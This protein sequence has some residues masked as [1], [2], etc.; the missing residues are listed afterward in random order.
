MISNFIRPNTSPQRKSPSSAPSQ[1][2]QKRI[3]SGISSGYLFKAAAYLATYFLVEP[4]LLVLASATPSVCQANPD[5]SSCKPCSGFRVVAGNIEKAEILFLGEIHNKAEKTERCLSELTKNQ[6]KHTVLIEGIP[7]HMVVPCGG[8]IDSAAEAPGR[9]CIGWDTQKHM[10][11]G[12]AEN[13]RKVLHNLLFDIQN[14]LK[15]EGPFTAEKGKMTDVVLKN[16]LANIK[17]A[18]GY[19]VKNKNVPS[20]LL[21]YL[22]VDTSSHLNLYVSLIR[23]KIVFD[24]ILAFR[25]QGISY[26]EILNGNPV[27][28]MNMYIDDISPFSEKH[29]VKVERERTKSLLDVVKQ[30][31]QFPNPLTAIAGLSHYV[32]TTIMGKD[33]PIMTTESLY[34]QTKLQEGFLKKPHAIMILTKNE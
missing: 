32:H 14:S 1:Q 18:L 20:S 26:T 2:T 8:Q 9:T 27:N 10:E 3:S 6:P 13:A 7:A 4:H 21:E 30:Q 23:W 33:D 11:R 31:S 12:I 5:Y 34:F 25:N 16:N 29:R 28:V 22:D 24:A 17:S 15:L 19:V